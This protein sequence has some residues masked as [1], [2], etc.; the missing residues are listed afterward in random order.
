M[1]AG[2]DDEAAGFNGADCAPEDVDEAVVSG[3]GGDEAVGGAEVDTPVTV[4]PLTTTFAP[5]NPGI[6]ADVIRDG[7]IL[8]PPTLGGIPGIP[9]GGENTFVVPAGAPGMGGPT[10][11]TLI[12]GYV[13]LLSDLPCC[14]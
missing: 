4:D 8:P 10:P 14:C 6:I 1:V 7:P 11:E 3:P 2:D 5:A 13:C 12:P 9:E